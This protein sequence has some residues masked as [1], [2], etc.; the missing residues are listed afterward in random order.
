M[1]TESRLLLL[2]F[3]ESKNQINLV[4]SPQHLHKN[5]F[6]QKWPF[7][8]NM[9]IYYIWVKEYQQL[10]SRSLNRKE[11]WRTKKDYLMLEYT[12]TPNNC[13]I[14]EMEIF[15]RPTNSPIYY[16]VLNCSIYTFWFFWPIFSS[17]MPY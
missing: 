7:F 8:A 9:Y 4:Y 1:T 6:V 15:Q 3:I 14:I 5:R 10:Y 12:S 11:K 17:Y 2:I 13:S 16:W